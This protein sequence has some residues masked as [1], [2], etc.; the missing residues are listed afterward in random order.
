MSWRHGEIVRITR[1]LELN[2]TRK[3][4]QQR[5]GDGVALPVHDQLEWKELCLWMEE[6]LAKILWVRIKRRAGIL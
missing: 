4:R 6:E 1:L 5:Q 2:D 3:D